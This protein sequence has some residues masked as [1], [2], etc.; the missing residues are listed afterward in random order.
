[1]C[2]SL[3]RSRRFSKSISIKTICSESG[4]ALVEYTVLLATLVLV[5]GVTVE[6]LGN[7]IDETFRH[8]AFETA[9]GGG[10]SSTTGGED[11]PTRQLPSSGNNPTHFSEV[12]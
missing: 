10:T 2:N 7:S 6:S 9:L 1:M 3:L 11:A 4:A 5:T 12:D 8:V